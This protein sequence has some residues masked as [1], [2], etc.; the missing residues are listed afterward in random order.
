MAKQKTPPRNL[1]ELT[2]RRLVQFEKAENGRVT[3][4]IPKFQKGFLGDW[5]QPRLRRPFF[6]VSLDEFGSFVW[7]CCDGTTSVR[8][9]GEQMKAQFGEAAEPIYDRIERFL[10][11]LENSQFIDLPT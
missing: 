10:Q 2:P 1:Y 9:I 11:Q 7:L 3:L 4:L 6:R 5:L 8:T